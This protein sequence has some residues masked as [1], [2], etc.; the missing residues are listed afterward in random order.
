MTR[1][2]PCAQAHEDMEGIITVFV[3]T[4]IQNRLLQMHE[5]EGLVPSA[6]D[7]MRLAFE[8]FTMCSM[9]G[10]LPGRRGFPRHLLRLRRGHP[11]P[12]HETE[13]PRL[14]AS[15]PPWQHTFLPA[16]D[17]TFLK[18]RSFGALMCDSTM[19]L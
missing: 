3:D 11:R 9:P 12:L 5:N 1:S 2:T 14:V 4:G 6:C 10:W 17:R 18:T 7:W 15:P 13:D 8:P 19:T 16:S